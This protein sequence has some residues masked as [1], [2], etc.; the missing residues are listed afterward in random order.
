MYITIDLDYKI[1]T[2]DDLRGFFYMYMQIRHMYWTKSQLS[3]E[4]LFWKNNK[5]WISNKVM[6]LRL[7]IFAA[8]LLQP[9]IFLS[10]STEERKAIFF[11][12]IGEMDKG[13]TEI[14]KN[15][16]NPQIL[17]CGFHGTCCVTLHSCFIVQNS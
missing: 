5:Y 11:Q 14:Q 17:V 1:P 10:I 3:E 7:L 16:K 2:S 13:R 15:M 9:V 6:K 4:V 8:F 12:K